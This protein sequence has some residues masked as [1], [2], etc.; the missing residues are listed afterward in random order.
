MATLDEMKEGIRSVSAT[1][2]HHPAQMSQTSQME[3]RMLHEEDA[4]SY[5]SLRLEPF[6]L[7]RLRSGKLQRSIS[8]PQWS[9]RAC[10][11]AKCPRSA[12]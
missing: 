3:I 8:R 7:S 11:F 9:R 1:D 2:A 4:A 10:E 12:F 5:W 6:K